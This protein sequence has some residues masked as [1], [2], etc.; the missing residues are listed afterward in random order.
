MSL[1]SPLKAEKLSQ[2][3]S[4]YLSKKYN[5]TI[6][7][8]ITP[9]EETTESLL[10]KG[11]EAI[12]TIYMERIIL[13]NYKDNFYSERLLQ[14][15]LS[16]EP[17]PG[18][19]FQFKYVPPQNYP[20]FKISEK[21]YFYPLFFGNT[22][23]LFI[24]LWR[25]NRSFKSFFIE[26]EKNYSFSGLLSQLKLVTELSFTRFNH[27]A[28]ESLQEIQKIWDEGMLRG[29]ISAFKKPSSLLFVCNRALPENFNG[30][31]GR[32]HSK[33]GSLNY[34]IFEKADLEEIRSQLKGFSGT[35][36][37][38]TFEKWKEEPFKRFNPLLL[39]FAVY[40]HARRAGL[41]F[42]LLDGFTLHVLAD[43]YYEWEDLGRALK[44]YELARAFTLQPIELALSEASIYYA[45][46]ELE[47]AEKTLRG[48]LCGCVKEDPRIHYN[49]GIIYKEKGEKEK[50]EYHLYKA[51]L[52][53]E[54]N[55]L[56]RKDLLKF[57]WDEGRWEEMEAILTKVKNFTKID[58]IFLGKL[59]FLK[60]DYAKALT[61]LKEIIDS[62]ERDG[63]SLYFLA[64]LYLYYKRDLSA[65][66]LFLKEAKHQ[67]SRG[68][69][70]KL[71]EEFGLPR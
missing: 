49:L 1:V 21:L 62:P 48:K 15:L 4:L 42:H 44:V 34:Y 36:G 26:L 11:N 7:D 18:Y 70:E 3:L 38:V 59:S 8:K 29:W 23:E 30:F 51:Y 25:K 32:I 13:E 41:K 5:I 9:F 24:E 71:V 53:E 68:A 20:F 28:R 67:L 66:D 12:P 57:L 54:E 58:K 50:A 64:W 22:K 55:P 65:A 6:S 52:L 43:L 14:M 63:E 39:G 19:I 37:I 45:F 17:L 61:Y 35:I 56:F 2:L 33:E 10:E 31:S 40:E 16:V 60:K 69:Y 27:R 46:S 47:K